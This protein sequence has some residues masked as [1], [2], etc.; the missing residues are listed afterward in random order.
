MTIDQSGE[1][2][3]KKRRGAAWQQVEHVSAHIRYL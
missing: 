1:A 2:S 3:G